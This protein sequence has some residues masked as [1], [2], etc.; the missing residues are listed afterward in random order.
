MANELKN[1]ARAYA[2][3]AG[4]SDC[5]RTTADEIAENLDSQLNPF[6]LGGELNAGTCEGCCKPLHVGHVIFSYTDIDGVHY[7][8]KNPYRIPT[9]KELLREEPHFPVLLAGNPCALMPIPTQSIVPD[10]K[11]H[12]TQIAQVE[13]IARALCHYDGYLPDSEID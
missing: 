8:C 11:L 13:H 4:R 5:C 6:L 7:D 2:E 9:R 1:I 10:S 3:E 12:D